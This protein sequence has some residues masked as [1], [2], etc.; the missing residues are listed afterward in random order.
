MCKHSA[1]QPLNPPPPP[2]SFRLQV[3]S[4]LVT[5]AVLLVHLWCYTWYFSATLSFDLDEFCVRM[6]SLSPWWTYYRPG[7]HEVREQVAVHGVQR[8]HWNEAADESSPRRR[9]AQR[10]DDG[11]RGRKPVRSCLLQVFSFGLIWVVTFLF[12]VRKWGMECDSDLSSSLYLCQ[13]M[14]PNWCSHN[15]ATEAV[16][17]AKVK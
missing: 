7:W 4:F 17:P 2:G 1:W 16:R 8:S 11:E 14:C 3:R 12:Q 6:M 15:I 5:V 10:D 9:S 13:G